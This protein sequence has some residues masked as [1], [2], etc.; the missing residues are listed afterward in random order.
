MKKLIMALMG[1]LVLIT[2]LT[3]M[4]CAPMPYQGCYYPEPEVII[5]YEPVPY[6]VPVEVG[7]SEPLPPRHTPL[8]KPRESGNPR[9][10]TPRGGLS[11]EG[12]VI[13]R[14][15]DR[16]VRNPGRSKGRP[17]HKPGTRGQ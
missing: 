6:P 11:D 1:I 9:I 5:I 3:G 15:G 8:T 4:G 17:S 13:A 12:P 7:G 16:P 10:K 2:S 14:G